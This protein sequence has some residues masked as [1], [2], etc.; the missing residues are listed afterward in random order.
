[1][2]KNWKTSRNY[3]YY[4][5]FKILDEIKPQKLFQKFSQLFQNRDLETF[6]ECRR[7]Y[8]KYNE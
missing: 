8:V 3:L 6:L 5:K 7:K 2:S 4:F 1:M